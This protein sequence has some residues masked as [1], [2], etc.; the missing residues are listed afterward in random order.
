M[1]HEV[2]LVFELL[3]YQLKS[4]IID[5]KKQ[6]PKVGLL[7]LTSYKEFHLFSNF[8]AVDKAFIL[9]RPCKVYS[10]ENVKLRREFH[11][12]VEIINPDVIHC[13]NFIDL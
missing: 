9:N 4:N 2:F 12:L 13:T 8:I 5:I 7:P 6:I 3:P 10:W 11:H 1:G